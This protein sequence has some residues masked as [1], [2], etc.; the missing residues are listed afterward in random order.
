ME[1]LPL[2]QGMPG[3]PGTDSKGLLSEGSLAQVIQMGEEAVFKRIDNARVTSEL[4]WQHEISRALNAAVLPET[5]AA[6]ERAIDWIAAQSGPLLQERIKSMH[7]R[8]LPG[9]FM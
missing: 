1:W 3:T 6:A 5:Y 9:T 8:L 4:L 7:N 2:R